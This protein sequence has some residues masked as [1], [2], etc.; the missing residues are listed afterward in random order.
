MANLVPLHLDK[1]TGDIVA[2]GGPTSSGG[3][4]TASGFLYEQIVPA[5]VW[6]I[7]H[8]EENDKVL[9]QI[10]DEVG[11]FTLPNEILIVD[12]NTVQITFNTPMAG[13]AHIM[14]FST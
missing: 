12:I 3:A 13:T 1:D 6:P 2:R 7:P 10:Y 11:E 8:N 5:A 4:A 9:V 14:F